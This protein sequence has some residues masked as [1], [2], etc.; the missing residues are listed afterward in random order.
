MLL[1]CPELPGALCSL[2]DWSVCSAQSLLCMDTLDSGHNANNHV[3]TCWVWDTYSP[4]DCVQAFLGQV[5]V[6]TPLTSV[7]EGSV[8]WLPRAGALQSPRCSLLL[9]PLQAPLLWG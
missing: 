7:T 9:S 3:H 6:R 4:C 5:G 8:G 1:I 2:P